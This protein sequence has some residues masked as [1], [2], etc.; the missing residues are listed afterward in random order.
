V[1][2]LALLALLGAAPPPPT[3]GALGLPFGWP[4]GAALLPLTVALELRTGCGGGEVPL[5]WRSEP[6]GSLSAQ[7]ATE[8]VEAEVEL[9]PE[10]EGAR[11][12]A[13]R[14]R[15]RRPAGLVRAAL[16]LAWPGE[17]AA[18]VGR[19]LGAAPLHGPLRVGRGTPLL[20]WAGPALLL[21]GPGLAAA[22]LAPVRTGPWPGGGPGLEATLFLDDAAERPFATYPRCLD[23][24]PRLEAGNGHAYADL[25][26]KQPVLEARRAPGDED[27]LEAVLVPRGAAAGAAWSPA[28]TAPSAAERAGPLT[29]QR[30]PAGARAAVVLT[31]HADRT[32]PDALRAVLWGHS[33]RRA[34]GGRGAGLLGR[35]LAITRSFFVA[36]GPGSLEDPPTAALAAEL[37]EAGSEVALHSVTEGRD[38]REAVRHGLAA[39]APYQPVTWIDHEPYVNCEA[40]SSEGASTSETWGVSDVLAGGGVRWGWAAGDVAG[41]HRVEVVDLFQAA[42]PGSPS[43]VVYPL[44]ADRRL[45]IFQSSFFYA[46]PAA[47]AAALSDEALDRLEATQGLFVGHT[48]LGAG[49]GVTRGPLAARLAVHAEAGG[50]LAIDAGLDQAFARL[51]ARAAEGRLASLTWAAAGDRLRALGE[52]A[53]RFAEGGLVAVVENRGAEDLPGL[54]LS[55]P[56]GGLAFTV[57][58]QPAAGDAEGR[59]C[60]FD[61][62]AGSRREVRAWRGAAHVSLLP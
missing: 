59:R 22:R 7:G 1:S 45:W 58:G 19:D 25:E 44:P 40:L 5:A 29:L 48:Y 55:V 34:E 20:A 30:W 54:T 46:P 50:A 62:P 36:P 53:L 12:L 39:A 14:L 9:S 10:P 17:A 47:L 51:A 60:W 2:L 23:A 27:A 15:W 16:R 49:P 37:L 31:D 3:G 57:D 35:G 43:P 4:P 21:G 8:E 52:V 26:R 32:E 33:D 41:F 42:P 13:V 11:A 28:I 6:D 56:A 61:L 38:G 18:A 24:L